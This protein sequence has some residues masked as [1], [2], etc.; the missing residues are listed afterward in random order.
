MVSEQAGHALTVISSLDISPGADRETFRSLVTRLVMDLDEA[1]DAEGVAIAGRMLDEAWERIVPKM[2]ARQEYEAAAE[3]FRR[4]S[5]R[6]PQAKRNAERI[7]DEAQHEY[8]AARLSL[9][10]FEVSPG[11]PRPEYAEGAE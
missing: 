9:A 3:R 10:R 4:A 7:A 6:W 2:S 5:A 8:E 11:V 1:G